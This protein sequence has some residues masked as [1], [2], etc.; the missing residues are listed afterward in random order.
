MR[1]R[2]FGIT[3]LPVSEIVFGGGAVGGL[4]IHQPDDSKR[5]AIR[6]AIDAGINWIDTA[7]SY[8]DGQS[9]TALGWL[10]EEMD[11]DVYVSTKVFLDNQ[12]L[13]DIRGQVERSLEQ[14]LKRLRMERV[15]VLQLHNPLGQGEGFV[16]TDA[17]LRD[18]GVLDAMESLRDQ[19]LF[20]H[21]GMTA[22]GRNTDIVEVIDSGRFASAQVYYNCLNPT[23]AMSEP[24]RGWSGHD[25][26]GVLDAC[27]RHG[28][29]VM[30]IRVLAAGVLASDVRHGRES[31]PLIEGATLEVEQRRAS[32]LFADVG[33]AG[34]TRAQMALRYALASEAI[35]C[36][37]I[38]LAEL[39]HLAEALAV[40]DME[41]LPES[42]IQ[43]VN[44]RLG[45]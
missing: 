28:L 40:Q 14:S 43:Q 34:G 25:F 1:Y 20:E 4:L 3:D 26:S 29:A 19:H 27:G 39:A 17:V 16:D 2:S 12:R 35:S 21:I 24:P 7:P 5:A 13:D 15:D 37:V 18:G 38:G 32:E 33:T 6:Q 11:G 10:L 36:A 44:G 23:A 30:A 45:V 31:P 9:E 41:T 42:V 22:L 8:G